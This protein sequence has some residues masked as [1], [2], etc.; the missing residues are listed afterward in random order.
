[1][2]WTVFSPRNTPCFS[3]KCHTAGG[4]KLMLRIQGGFC[5][6]KEIHTHYFFENVMS[7][8]IWSFSQNSA[9]KSVRFD[10]FHNFQDLV[11]FQSRWPLRDYPRF[12]WRSQHHSVSLIVKF[13]SCY[14]SSQ[15][16]YIS[17]QL[18]GWSFCYISSRALL[19]FYAAF[20]LH[21]YASFITFLCR[22]YISMQGCYIS[23][24][25]ITFLAFITFLCPT[26]VH[27]KTWQNCA[28]QEL[29]SSRDN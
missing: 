3:E 11:Y 17:M 14:I 7:S 27:M 15:G 20:L 1:M 9:M 24:Q 5:F 2:I 18:I 12:F 19:H 6:Y 16:Y 21:F 10:F 22:Y 23:M 25:V 28:F 8:M 13:V 4:F 29:V 26:S